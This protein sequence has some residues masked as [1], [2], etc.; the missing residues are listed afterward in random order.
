MARSQ[1]TFAV[2]ELR[3]LKGSNSEKATGQ[4]PNLFF[5]MLDGWYE[6]INVCF[7][8][9]VTGSAAGRHVLLDLRCKWHADQER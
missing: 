3:P 2:F 6:S 5:I 7:L 9:R 4:N 8:T 1:F